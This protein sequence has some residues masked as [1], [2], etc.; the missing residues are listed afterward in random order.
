[1]GYIVGFQMPLSDHFQISIETV[2]SLG[3]IYSYSRSEGQRE[4]RDI[5]TDLGFYANF[6]ALSVMYRFST[7]K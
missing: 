1:M 4:S 5:L 6:V 7:E 3:I 2:P